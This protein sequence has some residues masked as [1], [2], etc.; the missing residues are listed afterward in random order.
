[1]VQLKASSEVIIFFFFLELRK[2]VGKDLNR[3]LLLQGMDARKRK[4]IRTDLYFLTIAGFEA[5]GVLNSSLLAQT[6]KLSYDTV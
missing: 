3:N 4:A 6:V 2:M 1:M 5:L